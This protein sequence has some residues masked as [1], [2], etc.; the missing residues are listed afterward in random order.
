MSCIDVGCTAALLETTWH[1]KPHD[2]HAD[3]QHDQH[4]KL[5]CDQPSGRISGSAHLKT[6]TAAIADGT[7]HQLTALYQRGLY[8]L[9][10]LQVVAAASPFRNLDRVLFP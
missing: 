5:E 9:G 6:T 10:M 4:K 1:S 7:P 2:T 3:V 8:T